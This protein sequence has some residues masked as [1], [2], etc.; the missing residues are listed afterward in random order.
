M[1]LHNN[2]EGY[3]NGL[4]LK[5]HHDGVGEGTSG[6]GALCLLKAST[7]TVIL[8]IARYNILRTELNRFLI[9]NAISEK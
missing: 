3:A 2:Q 8:L 1:E 4:I 5:S 7:A 6:G 9:F